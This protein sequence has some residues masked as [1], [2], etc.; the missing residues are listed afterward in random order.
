MQIIKAGRNLKPPEWWDKF[1]NIIPDIRLNFLNKYICTN[2]TLA[3]I[4]ESIPSQCPFERGYYLLLEDK[5]ILVYYVPALCK[6]NPFYNW[7]IDLKLEVFEQRR[8]VKENKTL[9]LSERDSILFVK[10]LINSGDIDPEYKIILENTQKK[11]NGKI[12]S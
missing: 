11:S 8:F 5:K 12:N 4:V 2:E 7:I 1:T 9:V 10:S 6:L 3:K